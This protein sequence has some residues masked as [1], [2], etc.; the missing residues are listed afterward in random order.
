MEKG[1]AVSRYFTRAGD[2]DVLE[3]IEWRR[4]NVEISGMKFR[5]EGVEIP[6]FWS[7]RAATVV[8]NKYFRGKLGTPQREFSVKQIIRRVVGRIAEWGRE[9]SY[10]A[11]T[12]DEMAFRDEL[13]HLLVYQKMAFNS[14]V[15]FNVGVP[16]ERQQCSACFINSVEDNME[17]ILDLAK[18]E[19]MIFK[20]GS[21]AGVNLSK[22]RSSME[23]LSGG[24]TASGPVSFMKG[25][26]SFAGVIKSGGKTRRAAKMEVLNIDHPDVAE[27]IECKAHEEAKAGVLIDAGYDGSF[28]GE[29]YASIFFQNANNSVRVTDAFMQAVVAGGDWPLLAVTTGETVAVCKARELWQKIAE[30][31]HVCGDP[32]LQ[33]DTVTND[34]HTCAGTDRIHASNPCSEFVFLNN[35][36]C[37]LASLNLRKFVRTNGTF[38]VPTFVH[39]VET[40]ILAQEILVDFSDYPTPLIAKN[41]HE[42]RPLGL[43]YTNLG[44]LLM[45][46]GLPYDSD[47]GR[48]YCGAVTGLM[49]GAAYAMS[50]KISRWHGGPFSGYGVNR[51]SMLRVMRQHAQAAQALGSRTT[52]TADAK[53]IREAAIGVWTE[54]AELGQEYGFRNAQTT[55]LAPTGTISFMMD[56]DTT[57]I[58]PDIALIKYKVLAGGGSLKMVNHTVPEALEHLG[59]KGKAKKEILA[60]LEQE[61][62]I[63]GAP[64]LKDEHLPVFDCAFRAQ[65]GLRT[66]STAAHLKMMAAA[67]PFLSGAISKTVNL[68]ADATVG[69]VEA[70]YM[71]AWKL[72][73]KCVAIYRDGCKRSQPLSTGKAA[74]GKAAVATP[75]LTGPPP[76]TR[77]RL[78]DER[79]SIAHRFLVGGHKGYLHVGLYPNGHPGELF[80]KMAKEGSTVSGLMDALGI[81]MSLALQHGVPLQAMVDKLKGMRFDPHGYTSNPAVRHAHSLVDYVARWM[82]D[83]FLKA[84]EMPVEGS[85]GKIASARQDLTNPPCPSC[86]SVTLRAGACY[87]CEVCGTTTGCG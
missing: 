85:D 28:N 83:K 63:E 86:G 50:A 52:L 87:V 57:G 64:G 49:G 81:V 84:E 32:G 22:I 62:T 59:Y 12:A 31:A 77:H 1:L 44:A 72:G 15:W 71:D 3:S 5:Q 43:G 36:A 80:V 66:I 19:G 75:D 61:E 78:P 51:E 82:Q 16:G 65:K 30:A 9:G 79:T 25:W 46:A 6:S 48:D 74:D 54:A 21:G 37:N 20:L 2:Q 69:D 27:F 68:P 8:A 47:A 70:A 24:G 26:D 17:S 18:I 41:S 33:F 67:Q 10:F 11:S 34:W 58:E 29:A 38:D 39:A 76:V 35:T 45:A 73:L 14:P 40:T 56:A 7:E 42:F 4:T 13:T 60:Y 23:Y 53:A 55:V